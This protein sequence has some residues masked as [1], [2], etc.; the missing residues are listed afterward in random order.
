MKISLPS[1]ISA[2]LLASPL[3]AAEPAP[4]PS[5]EPAPLALPAAL[6]P[7]RDIEITSTPLSQI[8][9]P[10][11]L[12]P[13]GTAQW[14]FRRKDY[15]SAQKTAQN[16]LSNDDAPLDQKADAMLLLSDIERARGETSKALVTLQ[17]WT[18]T[19]P[20]H[21]LLPRVNFKLGQIF[22]EMGSYDRAREYFYRS[23]SSLVAVATRS[24]DGGSKDDRRL[25]Q[26][27]TWELAET[28][29]QASNWKRA[30][31]LFARFKSQ[32]TEAQDLVQAATYRQADCLY[33]LGNKPEAIR[34]YE[35]IL[36]TASFHPF[37]PEAWLKLITLYGRTG[38]TRQQA[39]ALETFIWL[40][41]N[42][43]PNQA[44]YWQR[45]C[46]STLIEF[47]KDRP[48]DVRALLAALETPST[49]DG[50]TALT[51]FL[52]LLA[53]RSDIPIQSN[54][55]QPLSEEDKAWRQWRTQAET[56]NDRFR[57]RLS[58]LQSQQDALQ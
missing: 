15:T 38:Q 23:L 45:R 40:I 21:R 48:D 11:N 44:S 10:N 42:T 14:F 22:R 31:D 19:F 18:L 5:E 55:T 29:F 56:N 28:E 57:Q 12:S 37:A 13:A 24:A 2:L 32:N 33:N 39:K 52:K 36:A 41:Q 26:A 58:E 27:A 47:V 35:A 51:L 34:S 30:Y 8:E 53:A 54:N 20:G 49:Q 50:W 43:Y 16:I 25:A 46:A 6:E 1:L 3:V 4:A 17:N 9:P 7:R